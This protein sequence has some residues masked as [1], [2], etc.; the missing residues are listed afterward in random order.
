LPSPG[1]RD[2]RWFVDEEAGALGQLRVPGER[3][4]AIGIV[5]VQASSVAIGAGGR[6]RIRGIAQARPRLARTSAELLTFEGPY[7]GTSKERINLRVTGSNLIRRYIDA[8]SIETEDGGAVFVIDDQLRDEV[9]ALKQL[10]WFYVIEHPHWGSSSAGSDT[11]SRACSRS[12]TAP[13]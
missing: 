13:R 4:W 11:S 9:D 12:T 6:D 1:S 2:D 10:I 7:A 3:V 8:P 5:S